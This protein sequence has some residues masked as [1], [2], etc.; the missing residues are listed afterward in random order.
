MALVLQS[1]G[2]PLLCPGLS[3][4][5]QP[6]SPSL[7]TAVS[8]THSW[9][10][11]RRRPNLMQYLAGLPSTYQR[12]RQRPGQNSTSS[13]SGGG[14]HDGDVGGG[15]DSGGDGSGH[16]GVSWHDRQSVKPLEWHLGSNLSSRPLNAG[17]DQ[18]APVDKQEINKKTKERRK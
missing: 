4:N 18:Q 17:Q 2:G 14:V 6:C 15:S 9:I 11:H 8:S 12:K 1:P 13:S 7:C 3:R 16:D 5:S 10:G